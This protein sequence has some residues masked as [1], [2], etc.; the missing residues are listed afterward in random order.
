MPRPLPRFY[1]RPPRGHVIEF[2]VHIFVGWQWRAPRQHRRQQHTP[3]VV[4]VDPL[5]I[6]LAGRYAGSYHVL[7]LGQHFEAYTDPGARSPFPFA[8]QLPNWVPA[9]PLLERNRAA[10]I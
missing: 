9:D 8:P 4:K 7:E 10:D 1:I 3:Q 6:D 5:G 2:P